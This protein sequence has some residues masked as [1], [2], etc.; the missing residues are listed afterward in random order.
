[1]RQAGF[2]ALQWPLNLHLYGQGFCEL[3]AERGL[4]PLG[5]KRCPRAGSKLSACSFPNWGFRR[6]LARHKFALLLVGF[7]EAGHAV[8][9]TYLTAQALK[10]GRRRPS[11][12]KA[13]KVSSLVFRLV[14]AS[15]HPSTVPP[16][17]AAARSWGCQ[18]RPPSRLHSWPGFQWLQCPSI[19][20][21]AG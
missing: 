8:A 10:R 17:L 9:L 7:S 13:G 1:M 15:P 19:P 12:E 2:P 20:R 16:G 6:G 5:I 3:E 14:S 4:H 11:H 18:S 21:V